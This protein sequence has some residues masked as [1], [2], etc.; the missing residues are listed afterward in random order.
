MSVTISYSHKGGY[1][2]TQYTYFSSFMQRL[3]RKFFTSPISG[4]GSSEES[5]LVW[6]H[7]SNDNEKR[8][9]YYG[10]QIGSGFSVTFNDKVSSNKIYKS[11]SL[12]ATSNVGSSGVNSFISNSD[13]QPVKTFST[14]S[15]SEKGGIMYAHIGNTNTTIDNSNLNVV[16]TM[17]TVSAQPS[18]SGAGSNA[19]MTLA[20]GSFSLIQSRSSVVSTADN[21]TVARKSKYLAMAPD[22]S[23]FDLAYRPIAVDETFSYSNLNTFPSY[24]QL[25]DG[26]GVRFSASSQALSGVT[27]LPWSEESYTILE[28]TQEVIN[29]APPRG[30]YAQ[31][32]FLL[33]T[34][35]YEIYA[36]NVN[37]EPTGLDHSK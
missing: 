12:E 28:V 35:P 14:G 10:T 29:G 5:S 18:W 27:A 30:Q 1:W 6:K 17:T 3:G 9:S 19:G 23:L 26:G 22:G 8:C 21:G 15:L 16:G 20:A 32:E 13:N 2:K 33:G 25:L 34:E 4:A 7:N 11:I 31:A 37:Y 36:I 24:I